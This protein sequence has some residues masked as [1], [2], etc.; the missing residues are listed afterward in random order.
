MGKIL[1]FP[2]QH[3]LQTDEYTSAIEELDCSVELKSILKKEALP[4]INKYSNLIT[5]DIG[6]EIPSDISKVNEELITR[7][8][9]KFLKCQLKNTQ[10]MMLKDIIELTVG[11]SKLKLEK[12]N[13]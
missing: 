8:V 12:N 3:K 6:L 4:Y 5:T 1:Q 9:K 10:S 7:E 13:I 2:I 11:I